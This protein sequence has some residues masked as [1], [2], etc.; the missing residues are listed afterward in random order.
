M[1]FHGLRRVPRPSPAQPSTCGAVRSLRTVPR[2]DATTSLTDLLAQ[3]A[4]AYTRGELIAMSSERALR[5]AVARGDVVR[6]LHDSYVASVHAKSFAARAD[7]ALAWPGVRTALG[8]ASALFLR[9][10]LGSCPERVDLCIGA[11]DHVRAP[12]WVRVRHCSYELPTLQLRRVTL[13]TPAVAAVQA[14]GEMDAGR[15]SEVVF[16]TLRSGAASLDDFHSALELVPRVRM[17]RNLQRDLDAAAR[18]AESWLEAVSL[19]SVLNT[20]EFKHLIPQHTILV[21]G[22]TFRLDL[23]DAMTR[24]AIEIDGSAYHSAPDQRDRDR[25]RDAELATAGIQTVRLTYRQVVQR[26][27]WCRETVRDVLRARSRRA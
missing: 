3:D 27:G 14:Y 4:R 12:A 10:V 7:A 16:A 11:H 20:D 13:V 21:R 1:A 17:R 9:G 23:Y 22:M 26:P 8:G 24:T 15:R 2:A 5:N 6:L 18:G 19:R 25:I